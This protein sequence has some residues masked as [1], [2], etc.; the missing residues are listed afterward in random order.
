M[1]FTFTPQTNVVE[2]RASALTLKEGNP[3]KFVLHIPLVELH[4]ST[5]EDSFAGDIVS[6]EVS[7]SIWAA[8]GKLI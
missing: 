6:L 4:N 3:S 1:R 5:L 8:D 7:E 2:D